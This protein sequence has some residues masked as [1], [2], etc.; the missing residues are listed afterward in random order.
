ESTLASL[1]EKFSVAWSVN[2]MLG[3]LLEELKSGDH[4]VMMSN[5]DFQGLPRLLQQSLKGQDSESVRV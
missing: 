2:E 5:G 1:G 4:V 3:V